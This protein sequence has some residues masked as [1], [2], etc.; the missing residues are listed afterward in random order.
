MNPVSDLVRGDFA[1]RF[2][3]PIGFVLL[4]ST[5][6]IVARLGVPHAPPLGLLAIR[7]ALT[8][9]V[10]A[11][12]ILM[13]RAAWPGRRQ[14][15]HLVVS[16]VLVH[17]VYLSGVWCAIALGLPSA[18]SALIVNLQPILT[19]LWMASTGERIGLRRW[20][21]LVLGMLGVV[22]VVGS[23]WTTQSLSL[24]SV[25]LCVLSLAGITVGTLYQKRHVPSFDLRTGTFVQYAASLVLVGPLALMLEDAPY[26]WGGELVFA[27]VW[28]VLALSIGAVFLL[29]RLIARGS[30]TSVTSLLY[31]V[32]PCTA[33]MAWL[34]FDESYGW[35]A[36]A[37]MLCAATGVA[38]V[39]TAP[40]ARATV[41]PGAAPV[42]GS[43]RE[44][45]L[46]R[47]Q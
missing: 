44:V 29:F 32:P 41:A 17:A 7:L 18:V 15:A 22:L 8:L 10:L 27:L 11:P 26:T 5:G 28:S 40:A 35:L 14:L 38:L 6:F 4:W 45:S 39:Q 24:A 33:L 30:A 47:K 25:C 37:G 46:E 9:A 16:G 3:V 43:P 1:A 34:L 2:G 21:G 36:A 20:S 19:G 12:L 31:M 23:K 13:V 42:P